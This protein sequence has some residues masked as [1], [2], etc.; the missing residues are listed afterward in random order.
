M[1]DGQN[2][3]HWK[4]TT[5]VLR[6]DLEGSGLFIVG[7]ATTGDDPADFT[8]NC[9]VYDMIVLNYNG[10]DWSKPIQSRFVKYIREGGGAFTQPTTHYPNGKSITKSY[11]K[12]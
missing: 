6:E 8:P 10:A 4:A 2:N 1:V 11:A 9:S 3:H 7:A 12:H 5:P